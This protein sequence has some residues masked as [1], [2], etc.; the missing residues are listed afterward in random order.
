MAFFFFGILAF[1]LILILTLGL[2]VL[3]F[4][5]RLWVSV[6]DFFKK[7]F[8]KTE[9]KQKYAYADAGGGKS[10]SPEDTGSF[11]PRTEEGQERLRRFKEMSETVMYEEIYKR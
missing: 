11:S 5:R 7:H 9:V 8:S 10:K 6:V 1:V 2:S 3:M 4:V